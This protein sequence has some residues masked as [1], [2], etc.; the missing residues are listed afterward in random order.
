M[1]LRGFDPSFPLI[2]LGCA[3]IVGGAPEES[4]ASAQSAAAPGVSSQQ[5]LPVA[6]ATASQ[7]MS[8]ASPAS[9]LSSPP[10]PIGGPP[11]R[12]DASKVSAATTPSAPPHVWKGDEFERPLRELSNWV[13]KNGGHLTAAVSDVESGRE[14]GALAADAV[15][16]PASNE[17]LL[18]T[19]AVLA[20]FSADYRFHT[21]LSGKRE[22]D[23]VS[24]LVL[25]GNGDPSL[26]Q[27][28][29]T[30]L[31]KALAQSGV[32]R[33]E[34]LAIDQNYFDG[35]FTPPAFEQQPNE[36]AAF[37]AP[38]SAVALDRN[39]TTLHVAPGSLGQPARAWFE[40]PGFVELSGSVRTEKS[41][42]SENVKLTLKP[43][44]QRLSALVAGQISPG[45][46]EF[47]WA[48]RVEDPT[49]LAGYGLRQALE[50]AG[51]RLEGRLALGSAQ[52]LPELAGHDSAP[53]KELLPEL[54]KDS[55]N[56]YAETLLKDLGA[57]VK[58]L[59]G[60][61][62]NGADVV[63]DYLK[64]IDA[65]GS[66]T[67]VSNGSGLFDANR[68]SAHTLVKVLVSAYKSPATGG[69]FLEQL[70]VGGVDGTLHKRFLAFKKQRSIRAKTGTLNDVIAL[71]GFAL[72]PD[73]SSP[74]AFSIIV[75]GVA[76]KHAEVRQKIDAIVGKIAKELAAG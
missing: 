30:S 45:A 76:G 27:G 15:E 8:T 41:G 18:T 32:A 74:V 17:K 60:T 39:T 62:A 69:A 14:L 67:R 63:L 61:S 72:R 57:Q 36:W 16:N 34:K 48:R 9:K 12:N 20:H 68:V 21:A 51:I 24:V 75:S 71:S 11:Q 29:L 13:T 58:G 64:Q 53:L 70:A 22:G 42:R 55:D 38:V 66:D 33:V 25:Q 56:F 50:T 6:T 59:P 37:R 31:A 49:L 26:T 65:L 7:A 10:I 2:A 35:N 4:T 28:D 43:N 23:A 1:R 52:G 44:G 19:A 46:Q 5:S 73:G 40:P 54:G 47:R 3:L